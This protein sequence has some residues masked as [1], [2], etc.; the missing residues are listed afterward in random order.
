MNDIYPVKMSTVMLFYTPNFIMRS[1]LISSLLLII[2]CG[3]PCGKESGSVKTPDIT[4]SVINSD[5]DVSMLSQLD[6]L[7]LE[8][9]GHANIK[10][11][12]DFDTQTRVIAEYARNLN[13]YDLK[14]IASAVSKE[15]Q[16]NI[17]L[18]YDRKFLIQN[19]VKRQLAIDPDSISYTLAEVPL[20]DCDGVY[21]ETWIL[22][23]MDIDPFIFLGDVFRDSEQNNARKAIFQSFV[24]SFTGIVDV[25]GSDEHFIDLCLDFHSK[26]TKRVRNKNYLPPPSLG[27][28]THIYE[29][30]I[31][32]TDDDIFDESFYLYM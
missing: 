16:N 6:S 19:I 12:D 5:E 23:N 32:Q 1:L 8:Q 20:E 24:R 31:I 25:S 11:K 29:S 28:G 21:I 3:T 10:S 2:G 22:D 15:S 17:P 18:S 13:K 7:I 14:Q 30:D 4:S 26:H 9:V 27:V